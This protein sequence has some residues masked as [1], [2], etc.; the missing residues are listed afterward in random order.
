VDVKV[1]SVPLDL[2]A[3]PREPQEV[4]VV[5]EQ[6]AYVAEHSRRWGTKRRKLIPP[7]E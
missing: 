2:S 1:R 7:H 4:T 3:V 5:L 6:G